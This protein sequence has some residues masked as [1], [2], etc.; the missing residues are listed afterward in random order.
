MDRNVTRSIIED[1][2][3]LYSE[4]LLREETVRW[5]EQQARDNPEYQ[6][7]LEQGGTASGADAECGGGLRGDDA[8]HPAQ[9][10]GHAVHLVAVSF[11]MAISTSMMGGSFG[12]IL[13]YAVLGGVTFL[14][15]RDVR[16]VLL[17]ALVPIFVWVFADAMQ[18]W[19]QGSVEGIGFF[20]F[21]LTALGGPCLVPCCMGC[22]RVSDGDRLALRPE[23]SAHPCTV[24]SAGRWACSPST[25][26]STATR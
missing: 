3:P 20:G 26:R 17:V 18:A 19:V 12:F 1:L 2:L 6:H 14:F 9:A 4:G 23:E 5:L 21:L 16:L 11:F 7:L 8:Q 25:M 15:Y 13:W 24:R 22:S 10:V